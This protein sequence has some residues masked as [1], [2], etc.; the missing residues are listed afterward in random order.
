M[1][2]SKGYRICYCMANIT[3]TLEKP[4]KAAFRAAFLFKPSPF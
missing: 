4:F 2:I 1:K 3:L